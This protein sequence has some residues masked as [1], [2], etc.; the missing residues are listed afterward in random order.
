MTSLI[1]SNV[2]FGTILPLISTPLMARDYLQV[3]EHYHLLLSRLLFLFDYRY[4]NGHVNREYYLAISAEF[5]E[6]QEKI[7]EVKDLL[8]RL[9]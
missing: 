7:K 8:K 3:L 6:V 9:L 5:V 1:P 4:R 2:H